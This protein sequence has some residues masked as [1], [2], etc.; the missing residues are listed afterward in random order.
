MAGPA[1]TVSGPSQSTLLSVKSFQT[2]CF[3]TVL[4]LIRRLK[5]LPG[6]Q[7]SFFLF[8]F[9]GCVYFVRFGQTETCFIYKRHN[10]VTLAFLGIS[11]SF[12]RQNNTDRK[13]KVSRRLMLRPQSQLKK[14]KKKWNFQSGTLLT[15]DL[16]V[17]K[18]RR[19][20]LGSR[21]ACDCQKASRPWRG[22]PGCGPRLCPP[23]R[24]ALIFSARRLAAGEGRR[25]FVT[26]LPSTGF[27][28][29]GG[30]GGVWR[31]EEGGTRRCFL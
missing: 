12:N 13:L 26:P 4:L 5:L 21:G 1:H 24:S 27:E 28:G 2:L 22:V 18:K 29:G 23:S 14:T 3:F 15:D 10:K 17:P 11:V 9:S 19:R 31:W 16:K 6:L 7:F 20:Y 30:G 25:R 8:V